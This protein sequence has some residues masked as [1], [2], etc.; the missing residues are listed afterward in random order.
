MSWQG[1]LGHDDT[2]LAFARANQRGR[3]GG[4]FLFVGSEGVGKRTFAFALAKVL[5]CQNQT[6]HPDTMCDFQVPSDLNHFTP[7][8]ECESCRLFFPNK[9]EQKRKAGHVLLPNHPDFFYVCKPSNNS[10]IP[11]ALLVGDRGSRLS[12]GL[13]YEISRTSC[14]GGRKVV[15]MDDADYLNSEGANAL[16]KTLEEPPPNSIL[17][18]IGTSAAKQLP[19][20]RSRC[21]IIRFKDLEQKELVDIL[22]NRRLVE[23]R[24]QAEHLAV[25]A[26]GSISR[27]LELADETL[28][29]F[30]TELYR[31]LSDSSADSTIFARQLNEYVDAIGKDSQLRRRRLRFVLSQALNFF[32]NQIEYMVDPNAIRIPNILRPWLAATRPTSVLVPIRQ[33]EK[34]IDILGMI[35]RNVNVPYI[36]DAWTDS[37]MNSISK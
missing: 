23:S 28:E 33:A 27:A 10:D 2:A 18:L 6:K 24:E 3:L 31:A 5:L 8:N 17:I 20:I 13:C 4:S 7:C 25:G 30:N 36:V 9:E 26:N 21:Q 11:M 35:D 15:I 14:L 32:R 1:I 29:Q 34:T 16:L 37:V 22:W 19:T 12:S